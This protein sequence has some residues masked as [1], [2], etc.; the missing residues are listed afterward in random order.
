MTFVED[1]ILLQSVFSSET[2]KTLNILVFTV[3]TLKN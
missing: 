1:K 2:N 3:R